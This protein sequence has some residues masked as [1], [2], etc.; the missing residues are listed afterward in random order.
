MRQDAAVAA[1]NESRVNQDAAPATENE[2]TVNQDAAA[3][4][5]STANQDAAVA[6]ENESTVN[7]DAAAVTENDSTVNQDAAAAAENESTVNKDAATAA[8]I[9]RCGPEREGFIQDEL[10]R[11]HYQH[12]RNGHFHACLR[13]CKFRQSTVASNA[14]LEFC[15]L[16]MMT[17]KMP[18]R[19]IAQGSYV[20]GL[21]SDLSSYAMFI[22]KWRVF[23]MLDGA[24]DSL[25]A[26]S[27]AARDSRMQ[28]V[29]H[30]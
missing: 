28:E 17:Q 21:D 14:Q 10:G 23:K 6:A 9:K 11:L 24:L 12:P 19:N 27:G 7:Q 13:A 30:G 15:V 20:N 18:G 29:E 25:Q 26:V 22:T 8:R 5:E 4:N 2:S 16:K 1:E 3:E